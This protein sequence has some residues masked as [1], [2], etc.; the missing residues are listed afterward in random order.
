MLLLSQT[1]G[2]ITV[3]LSLKRT[4]ATIFMPAPANIWTRKGSKPAWTQ[5]H[6]IKTSRGWVVGNDLSLSR[7]LDDV[8]KAGGPR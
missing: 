4:I 8:D 5:E 7:W 6:A 1:Y 3:M 2:D